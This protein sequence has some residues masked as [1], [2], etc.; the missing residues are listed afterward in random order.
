MILDAILSKPDVNFVRVI[1]LDQSIINNIGVLYK[2]DPRVE[3]IQG[4]ILKYKPSESEKYDYIWFYNG[5]N[6]FYS[7]IFMYR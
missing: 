4:D 5:A 3:I 6:V 2:D 7:T 1:E